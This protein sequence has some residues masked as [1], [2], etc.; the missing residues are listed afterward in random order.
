MRASLG[1]TLSIGLLSSC[2]P[3][4]NGSI[5]VDL[6]IAGKEYCRE[7]SFPQGWHYPLRDN[8]GLD[9]P[10]PFKEYEFREGDAPG[11]FLVAGSFETTVFSPPYTTTKYRLNLSS[12]Q[13]SVTSVDNV[14]WEDAASK[15]VPLFRE[16]VF[17]NYPQLVASRG[18]AEFQGKHF[19]KT[20][21]FWANADIAATRLSPDKAW[22]VLQSR[23]N[24][25]EGRV[26]FDVFNIGT[27]SKLVTLEGPQH[28]AWPDELINRTGWLAGRYF[29]IPTGDDFEGSVIC[30]FDRGTK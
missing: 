23:T 21:E 18:A 9:Y 27:G 16:S 26:F 13:P 12:A 24:P 7:I 17:S 28:G 19:A 4:G 29:V 14:T 6:S 20:G 8:N 3:R 22:L 11:E 15:V 2:E 25:G 5:G 1:L 30:E 10:T